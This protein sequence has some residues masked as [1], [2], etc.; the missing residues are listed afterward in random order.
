HLR[1]NICFYLDMVGVT[2]S[3]P[4]A[5]TISHIKIKRLSG[6]CKINC[7]FLLVGEAGGKQTVRFDDRTI[8]AR[9]PASDRWVAS[10]QW[11]GDATPATPQKLF[12]I[13]T[14]SSR[15]LGRVPTSLFCSGRHRCTRPGRAGHRLPP[16]RK[17]ELFG[18]HVRGVV[19]RTA[20]DG[21]AGMA[22]GAAEV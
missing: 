21:A 18:N 5:P 17:P 20:S 12:W 8:C 15:A 2:G 10:L 4:V 6:D 11:P 22:T 9:K 13:I 19:T 3:I 14:C 7:W 16:F 1:A